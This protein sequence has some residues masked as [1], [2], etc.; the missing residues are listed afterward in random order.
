MLQ[1]DSDKGFVVHQQ[2]ITKGVI[3]VTSFS[4][5]MDTYLIIANEQNNF[6]DLDQ[7]IEVYSWNSATR[8]FVLIQKLLTVGVQHV[9]VFY[10][11]ETA[12]CKLNIISR[13]NLQFI[14]LHQV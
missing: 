2:L 7:N 1:F 4:T 14:Y 3:S 9:H 11:E 10:L 6:G 5:V 13:F 8:K 12:K